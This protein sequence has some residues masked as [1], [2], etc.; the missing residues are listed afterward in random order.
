MSMDPKTQKVDCKTRMGIILNSK[1]VEVIVIILIIFYSL[2]VLANIVLDDC[3]N[4]QGVKDA[5]NALKFVELGVVIL[6]VIEILLKVY[7]FGFKAR[8]PNF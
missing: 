8:R 7:G 1:L 3:D 2:L 5:L 6:F 4:G